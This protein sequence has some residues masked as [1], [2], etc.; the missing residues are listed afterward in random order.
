MAVRRWWR[1]ASTSIKSASTWPNWASAAAA[2][3]SARA[4]PTPDAA[5][6]T[7][8]L[9]LG[10]SSRFDRWS[11]NGYA[12]DTNPLLAKEANLVTL[13][14]VITAVSATRLSV[15][16]IISRKPAM[17]SL[18]DGFAEKSFL[19]AYKEAGFKTFWLSNQISFGKFDTPVS[20]FAKE[21]DV[22]QFLNLGGFTNNSNFDEVLFDPLQHRAGRRRAEK[23]DRAAFAGQPLELQP[24]LPEG[25]S[26]NGSRRCRASTSRSTPTRA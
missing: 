6:E 1:A 12:R 11:L 4:R 25:R 14:D 16:V 10:E 20:V 23:A 5:P 22:I 24:A 3:A 26:T 21:A 13:P 9:V 2:S 18:K 19:T 8:V 15:P 7:V 17:Q